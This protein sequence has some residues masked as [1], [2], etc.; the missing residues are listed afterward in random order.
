[1]N[2]YELTLILRVSE[3]LEPL[4]EKVKEILQKHGVNVKSEDAW[5]T[6]K[7][8]YEIDGEKDGCYI[9]L[10]IETLPDSVTKITSE[11]RLNSDILRYMFVRVSGEKSA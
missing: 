1:M 5:G 3:G 4:K 11:F 9:L 10:N 7:L 8:A 2:N 6:K